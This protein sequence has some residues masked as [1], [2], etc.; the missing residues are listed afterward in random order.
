MG[1][2]SKKP[3]QQ[4]SEYRLS[5]HMGICHGPIDA[6]GRVFI[7][8]KLVTLG[9]GTPGQVI[10]IDRPD[11]FG[12]IKKEGGVAGAIHYLAG[13][14]A[15]VM[16]EALAQ[17]FGRTAATM[18]GFRGLASLFFTNQAGARAGFYWTANTPF[19]KSVWAE[20]TRAPVGLAPSIALVPRGEEALVTNVSEDFSG[21]LTGFSVFQGSMAGFT[22]VADDF[23]DCLQVA[24]G[25]ND[26]DAIV[27]SVGDN[28]FSEVRVKFK[29][30]ATS[31]D[32][33]GVMDLR[34][35][36]D[37]I[38]FGFVAGREA[39][40]DSLRRPTVTFKDQAGQLGNP[41]GAGSVSLNVWYEFHAVYDQASGA[42]DVTVTNLNSSTVFGTASVTVSS[43]TPISK[44]IFRTENAQ[45]S[46]TVR[47]DDFQIDLLSGGTDANPA[48]IIYECLTNE[49][50]GLGLPSS[51]IDVPVFEAVAATLYQERLGLSM[52]WVQQAAI[53]TF[54]KEVL[55]H[56]NATVFQHPTTG[57]L[58]L[59]LIR[60]DYDPD[61]LKIL[62]PINFRLDSFQRKGLGE[63]VNELTVTYTDPE[64]EKD[65]T[66][67]AQDLGNISAQGT[68]VP[69]SRNFYGVR[70]AVLATELA[71]RDLRVAA[72]PLA[73]AEGE[74]DRSM[75]S[76]TPGEPVKLDWFPYGI[77]DMVMRIVSIDYGKPGQPALNLTMVEDVFALPASSFE[78]PPVSIH[79]DPSEVPSPVDFSR[80]FT[81]PYFLA[82]NAAEVD[83]ADLA[84][85]DVLVGILA[86][87]SGS[88]T[89]QYD[90]LAEETDA[91]GNAAYVLAGRNAMLSRASLGTILDQA[92]QSTGVLVENGTQGS[93]A[94]VGSFL[95]I[96]EGAE[97]ENE[98]CIVSAVG[99]AG[100]LT[101]ERGML[102]TT[103]RHWPAGTPVWILDPNDAFT[104]DEPRVA[105]TTQNYKILTVTSL[106]TLAESS[107]PVLAANL[108][109]RP[110]LPTRP[111][112]VSVAGSK[113]Q[114]VD[115]SAVDPIVVTWSRRN[116][117]TEDSQVLGW[118]DADVTPEVGETI[119]VTIYD[120][121]GVVITAFAGLTGTS[122]N[123]DPAG[124]GAETLGFVGVTS[125]RDGFESLQGHRVPVLFS[126]GYGFNYGFNYGGN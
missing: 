4:V 51:T 125:V 14:P 40:V 71:L 122:Y 52:M 121:D 29:V 30:T 50:F 44:L 18:P 85:P 5:T 91:L 16:P 6:L 92:A 25:P 65:A 38:V 39:S 20:V 107:A 34:D 68:V 94:V 8:E 11:L 12:G 69:D 100:D 112:N 9:S 57:L 111:A 96:G 106:G 126:K 93:P 53:E 81:L 120:R 86:A 95:V 123:L 76:L 33:Y 70:T 109:E 108:T 105:L 113:Y 110:H 115:V 73:A 56:I 79:E 48:H 117:L 35:S 61:T 63:T 58:T 13:G 66:V 103:P 15:Q 83:L 41:I 22:I 62:S 82:V 102:D 118:E 55:D 119:T 19:L 104:D 60:N 27:R 97:T 124:F 1:S 21:G 24:P 7:G 10:A 72:S 87:E 78:T 75:A 54:V 36:A 84:Y 32:D 47:W 2:K 74:A 114:S 26:N 59:K 116:R 23:G 3:K 45:G 77:D 90:L 80:A 17:K 99:G 43:R 42:F 28:P 98:I 37:N 31:N 49:E 88:D 89:S 64:T 67:T 46:G 101:L